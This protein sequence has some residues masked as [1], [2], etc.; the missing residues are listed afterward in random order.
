MI[1][2]NLW[3]QVPIYENHHKINV[4][5][6]NANEFKLPQKTKAFKLHIYVY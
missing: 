2:P 5:I 4:I 3:N 6:D 1:D